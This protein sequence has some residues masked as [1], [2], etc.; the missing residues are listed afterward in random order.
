ML[1]ASSSFAVEHPADKSDV[2]EGVFD[3]FFR[4]PTRGNHISGEVDAIAFLAWLST[5][6]IVIGV[7]GVLASGPESN[8]SESVNHLKQT[9][10]TLS[11]DPT[12]RER[13]IYVAR[14][15]A[16]TTLHSSRSHRH[17]GATIEVQLLNPG[18]RT[19]GTSSGL[20]L[21]ID[22]RVRLVAGDGCEL[23]YDYLEYRSGN[24][25]LSEWA[26][27]DGR[28]FHSGI[29]TSLDVLADEIVDQHFV[30]SNTEPADTARL[31]A[32]GLT[33]RI[34]ARP[35]I[36]AAPVVYQPRPIASRITRWR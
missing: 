32:L 8:A 23:Y 19:D 14:E 34:Q 12:L 27:D 10:R 35:A 15:R 18:L 25:R 6:V 4:D 28:L 22:A 1:P 30:R 26:A 11:L 21:M 31:S 20:R 17:D 3:R 2:A 13:V 36:T 24:R 7:S 5:S 9:S 29:V 16:A 33:R